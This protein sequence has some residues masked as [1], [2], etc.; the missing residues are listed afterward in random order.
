MHDGIGRP[1]PRVT[2][3]GGCFNY[4]QTSIW[5]VLF[6]RLPF[7]LHVT[8]ASQFSLFLFDILQAWGGILDVWWAHSGI[9]TTGPYCTAQGIIQ[10]VGE[11]G[12][13]LIT[14]VVSSRSELG[15]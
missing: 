1:F 11:L 4:L 10:Q 8:F 13:A 14:L 2:V 15:F 12:V 7:T 5:S 9:V 3:I 6:S